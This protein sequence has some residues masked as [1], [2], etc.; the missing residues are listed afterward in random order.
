MFKIEY[1]TQWIFKISRNICRFVSTWHVS[2]LL[3]MKIPQEST[4]HGIRYFVDGENLLHKIV[5][6]IIVGFSVAILSYLIYDASVSVFSLLI[7][8]W[9]GSF[10]S[11]IPVIGRRTQVS[12]PLTGSSWV[13][14]SF[15]PS[16][17]VLNLLQTA[18]LP[19]LFSTCKN[20]NILVTIMTSHLLLFQVW[21]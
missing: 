21:I 18:W 15:L 4:V 7:N 1:H 11:F 16:L 12:A 13:S 8:T 5:W 10:Q 6:V 17:C 3:F 20:N 9:V 2:Q 19:E 14:W